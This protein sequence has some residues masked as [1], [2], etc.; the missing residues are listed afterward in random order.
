MNNPD[1]AHVIAPPPLIFLAGFLVGLGLKWLWPT[2][3]FAGLPAVEPIGMIFAFAAAALALWGFVT[4][5][6]GGTNVD[7]RY[8]THA[9]VSTG[10]FRFSRNPL[11]LAMAMLSLGASLFF[12]VDWAILTLV[13]VLIVLNIGVI[14]REERY[15]EG[16]FGEQY[17]E[18]KKKVRIWL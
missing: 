5:R 9:I 18:Y 3:V 16:K 10:P 14:S 12:H 15:L 1:S 4:L 13:P 17:L 6:R 2:D 7:P 8:P 11:Y